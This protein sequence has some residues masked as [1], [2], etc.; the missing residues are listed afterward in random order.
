[1]TGVPYRE[2]LMSEIV[3][4]PAQQIALWAD[5]LR[6]LSA[7]GLYFSRNPYDRENYGIIRDIVLEMMA[8]VTGTSLAE[9]EPLRTP[10]FG[11]P[12]P[13]ATGDGAVIDDE[14]HIL[15]IRRA[16]TGLWAM[17]GG[18]L[19]VGETPAEGVVREVL[20]ETGVRCEA[21][22]LAGIYDSR[23][24]GTV[25]P[26]HLY[27]F[28]FLCRPLDGGQPAA[29]PSHGFEV[30]DAGWFAEHELP[31][32]M[33]PGHVSRIP[34][35]FRAWRGDERAYFDGRPPAEATLCFL[36]RGGPPREVL[37]GLKKT[38]L[39]AGKYGGF[40]GKVEPGEKVAAAAA[41]ELAEECGL[42]VDQR[43]LRY[44][45]RLTF[46]FP[47]KPDW[48]QRVHVFLATKWEGEPQ[49]STEMAPAWFGV[50][51]IPYARMWQD[52]AHWL[53]RILA[54]ERL[55]GRFVFAADNE[56]VAEVELVPWNGGL[57]T[58]P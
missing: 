43:D 54:G 36:L 56:T 44:A 41:R 28:V 11:R 13:L 55:R 40:G 18:A 42:E 52:G 10:F 8:L 12:T 21:V 6:D 26:H 49:E 53:P 20:E 48:G 27:Q 34:Q 39:G 38:G 19:T 25:S 7:M 23:L 37:L 35:A 29:P 15:L 31:A 33:D 16:D 2:A 4:S 1:V 24:C 5:K 17:P 50:D 58:S 32:D 30:L 47:F 46:V 45:G 51:E 3:T 14:G 57:G 22:A 9:I